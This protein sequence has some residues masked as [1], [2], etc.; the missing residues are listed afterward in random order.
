MERAVRDENM[1][2]GGHLSKALLMDSRSIFYTRPNPT[3]CNHFVACFTA[4]KS[5]EA[6]LSFTECAGW[7]S[8]KSICAF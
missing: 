7:Y 4:S 3:E 1:K 2:I 6:V 8:V 5:Q